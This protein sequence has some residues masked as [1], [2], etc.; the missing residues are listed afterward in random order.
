MEHLILDLPLFFDQVLIY[1]LH[2]FVQI[3][4]VS[5][6]PFLKL[7]L[8]IDIL[9]KVTNFLRFHFFGVIQVLYILIFF[10]VLLG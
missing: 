3:L 10:L 7:S 1:F 2:F 9:I 5:Y 6:H 8:L 4:D